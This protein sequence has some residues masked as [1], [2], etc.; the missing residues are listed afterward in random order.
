MVCNC[1]QRPVSSSHKPHRYISEQASGLVQISP[2]STHSDPESEK[3]HLTLIAATQDFGGRQPEQTGADEKLGEATTQS[4]ER[5][6][7]EAMLSSQ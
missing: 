1:S 3:S 2:K 5:Q 4:E 6:A 7:G